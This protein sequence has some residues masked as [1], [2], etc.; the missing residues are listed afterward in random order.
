MS[1]TK[2]QEEV[3]YQIIDAVKSGHRRIV[4]KGSAG[5]GKTFMVNELLRH[6][7]GNGRVYL[8]APTNKALAVLRD[9]IHIRGNFEFS[10]IH[11]ALKLKRRFD[12]KT[13][14]VFFKQEYSEKYPPFK[15]C[16]LLIIDESSM[17]NQEILRYLKN[18][19]FPII[20]I[21]DEKQLNPVN[22]EESP[23][24]YQNWL[25]FELTQI[26]RQ[27]GGNPIIEL[28]RDI[29]RIWKEN[30]PNV[31]PDNQGYLYTYDRQKV[32]DKLSEVNGSNELKYLAYT[33]MDVDIINSSVR[34]RIYGSPRMIEQGEILVF[35]APYG[36]TFYT[37]Q[38][39]KIEKLEETTEDYRT[40][41]GTVRFKTYRVNELIKV[42]HEDSLKDYK[43]VVKVI[44]KQCKLGELEWKE[45]Y[46]F[47]EEFADFKYN[48][49]ITVHKSQG[50]T[51][52]D[53]ILNVKNLNLNKSKVEKQR[54]F[55]TGITRA[56]DLLI[57]YNVD[58]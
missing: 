3:M 39:V 7:G 27:K 26:I 2:H 18:Y 45:Y 36:D 35:N 47:I 53:V 16:S 50:S 31:N 15:G 10:T 46:N 1:L 14:E 55:Y 54:L 12:N 49:A 57:L 51:Y 34:N 56:S 37:N 20:Y 9:K 48:H 40:Y 58:L 42:I 22:E 21:G 32:I 17:I 52:K 8:T 33:N 25:T 30:G 4:L 29:P 19:N 28:S 6:L 38:E 24:F 13:G 23:V 11:S 44:K 41:H 5:V 43:E